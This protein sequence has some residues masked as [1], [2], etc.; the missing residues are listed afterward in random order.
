MDLRVSFVIL[1]FGDNN[2]IQGIIGFV[3]E[4]N[5]SFKLFFDLNSFYQ[6][7]NYVVIYPKD[8]CLVGKTFL[9]AQCFSLVTKGLGLKDQDIFKFKKITWEFPPWLSGEQIR[10]GTMRCGFDP[11]PRSV[12]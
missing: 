2:N 3:A 1:H 10:I 11:W 8:Y 5:Y 4:S 6:T 9:L 7:L 12:G